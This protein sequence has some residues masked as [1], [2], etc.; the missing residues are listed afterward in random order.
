[1]IRLTLLLLISLTLACC[2][3]NFR[4][5]SNWPQPIQQ[6][7]IKS[8]SLMMKQKLEE[9]LSSMPVRLQANAPFQLVL[10]NY[11]DNEKTTNQTDVNEPSVTPKT[12]SITAELFHNG[13]LI[14]PKKVFSATNQTVST[15]NPVNKPRAN[16]NTTSALQN[17]LVQQLFFWLESTPRQKKRSINAT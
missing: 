5:A 4:T 6:L 13:K 11:T 15:S 9:Q 1:M 16:Q 10:L 8:N 14:R 17:D 2:G 12:I 7:E 3:F